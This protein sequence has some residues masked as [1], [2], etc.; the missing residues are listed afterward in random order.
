MNISKDL[1][2]LQIIN[3]ANKIN[4]LLENDN[5]NYFAN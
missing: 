2:F 5:Y 1:K 4:I 3:L